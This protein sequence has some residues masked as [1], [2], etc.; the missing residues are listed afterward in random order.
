LATQTQ[1]GHKHLV[2]LSDVRKLLATQT[3]NGHNHLVTL[4]DDHPRKASTNG[5]RDKPQVRQAFKAFTS[6]AESSTGQKVKILRSN[7]GGRRAPHHAVPLHDAPPAHALDFF[8]PDEALSGNKP[9]RGKLD[10]RSLG[11]LLCL[12]H[13][14]SRHLIV[15]RTVV[16]DEGGPT[17]HHYYILHIIILDYDSAAIIKAAYLNEDKK[18]YISAAPRST[19]AHRTLDSSAHPPLLTKHPIKLNSPEADAK[20]I[21]ARPRYHHI[22]HA[23]D[24]PRLRL[25]R[26]NRAEP[27]GRRPGQRCPAMPSCSGV[28]CLG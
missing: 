21:N 20:A 7:S 15:S 2:T 5:P 16:L 11:T 12:V 27:Y 23:R 3:Q 6:W 1:N 10:T 9:E 13:G 26:R 22:S 25:C 28:H 19:S 14:P 4:V 17:H 24:S 8:T 18:K